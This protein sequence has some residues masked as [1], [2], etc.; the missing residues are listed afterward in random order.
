M[1]NLAIVAVLILAVSVGVFA[2]GAK[3]GGIARQVAMGGSN[4]GTSLVLNPFIMDDPALML[5][6]PAYQAAYHDYGWANVASR[7]VAMSFCEP[8]S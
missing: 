1:K 4:A 6:N 8:R 5:V 3:S 7:I 2:Q